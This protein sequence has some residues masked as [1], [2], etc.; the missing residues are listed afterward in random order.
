MHRSAV[1]RLAVRKQLRPPA[2]PSGWWAGALAEVR[3]N[4]HPKWKAI[5][6]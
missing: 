2:I 4:V 6:T 3:E 5:H 1:N